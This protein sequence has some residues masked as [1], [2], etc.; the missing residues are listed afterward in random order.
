MSLRLRQV[1]TIT[2]G[3]VIAFVMLGLG[4]WQMASFQRSIADIAG[5]R[6]A[7]PSVSL[8]DN[9]RADGTIEDIYGRR[10]E[11]IGKVVPDRELLVG[12]E[13]PMRV[14]VP[15]E[16]TDGRI[17]P[18]VLGETD[19]ALEDLAIDGGATLDI[20]GVFTAGDT[21]SDSAPP[22]GA[23][24]GSKSSLRLQEIVQAWPQPMI[25][26]Y[27]TLD[28]DGARQ[29]DLIPATAMLPAARGTGMHQGYALQ[30]WVFAAA[31][32]A[33]SIVVARGL[34]PGA[35]DIAA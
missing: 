25:A 23:P 21:G 4:L 35:R 2:V 19:S 20:Q 26:G 13:W 34:K 3:V 16:T 27:V 7:Q 11:L 10:V 5:E 22:S 30:W 31:A 9:I 14:A 12:T 32:V 18:L 6:A 29:F 28:A 33:F 8:S 24:K 1:I 17:V 15:F